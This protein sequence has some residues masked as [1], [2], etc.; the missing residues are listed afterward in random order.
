[1]DNE[2]VQFIDDDETITLY[3]DDNQPM[4]FYEVAVVEYEGALYAL[5]QPAEKVEGIEEDEVVIFRI[6]DNEDD[7]DSFFYP[8]DDDAI[9]DAVFEEYLRAASDGEC[10]GDCTG[11]PSAEECDSKKD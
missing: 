10:D 5:L 4:E 8:V 7:E 9:A 2:K 1:M 11:C 3:D 6:E